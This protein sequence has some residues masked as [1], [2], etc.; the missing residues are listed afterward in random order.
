[1]INPP[2]PNPRLTEFS[3]KFHRPTFDIA[4]GKLGF[5]DEKAKVFDI[6][7]RSGAIFAVILVY[8]QKLRNAD[9][10]AH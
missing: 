4:A 7:I 6:A 9:R 8:W 3:L 1:L 5:D 10:A 2:P